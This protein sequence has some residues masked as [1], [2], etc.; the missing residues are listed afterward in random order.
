VPIGSGPGAVGRYAVRMPGG[1]VEVHAAPAPGSGTYVQYVPVLTAWLRCSPSSR[2]CSP[3]RAIACRI[4]RVTP[5]RARSEADAARRSRPPRPTARAS[6]WQLLRRHPRGTVQRVAYGSCRRGRVS[7]RQTHQ[8]ETRLGLPPNA[9]RGQERLLGALDVPL[10]QPDPS[11]LAER[12]SHL[13]SQVRAQ[14]LAGHQRLSFRLVARPAQPQ[15]LR[16]MHAAA[17]TEAPDGIRLAPPLHCLG[18]LLRDVVLRVPARR[19]RAR[20]TRARS[21]ADRDPGDRR[22]SNLVE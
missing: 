11:K 6:R 10:A 21:K 22:H 13:P 12:P 8:R 15:D 7:L 4:A 19:K 3:I 18:P 5:D 9:M 17:A 14:L 2:W 16:P 20:S 1:S